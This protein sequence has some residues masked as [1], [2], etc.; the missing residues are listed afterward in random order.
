MYK[1]P[2]AG[3]QDMEKA[4]MEKAMIR[5]WYFN[6]MYMSIFCE[7]PRAVPQVNDKSK[8]ISKILVMSP[9]C[10]HRN[11]IIMTISEFS[12]L[13]YRVRRLRS[14]YIS[15]DKCSSVSR[16]LCGLN[17]MPPWEKTLYTG[18]WCRTPMTRLASLAKRGSSSDFDNQKAI[19]CSSSK[20]PSEPS[21]SMPLR[22]WRCWSN[23]S[24]SALM[25]SS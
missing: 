15:C 6:D 1:L 19:G 22:Y 12:V 11:I 2:I 5:I 10:N 16:H 23:H 25:A 17:R 8:K 14:R 13:F 7:I 4:R 20:L 18:T 21:K 3:I 9:C 24:M